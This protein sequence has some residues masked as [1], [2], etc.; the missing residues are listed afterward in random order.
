MLTL[1]DFLPQV[2]EPG[3]LFKSAKYETL[4]DVLATVNDWIEEN[5]VHVVNVETVIIP[6]SVHMPGRSSGDARFRV[7]EGTEFWG[8]LIRVWYEK[9]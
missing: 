8:Q 4:V 2:A 7:W 1:K 3:G 6:V 9:V 5:G